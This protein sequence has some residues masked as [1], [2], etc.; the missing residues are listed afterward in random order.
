MS[1][2]NGIL[3]SGVLI[4]KLVNNLFASCY[5]INRDFLLPHTEYFDDSINL[6]FLVFSIFASIF[7]VFLLHFKQ[8]VS[9]FV[10]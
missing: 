4:L 6:P 5:F 7:F 9:M 2:N 8:Y 1:P 10:L 3:L